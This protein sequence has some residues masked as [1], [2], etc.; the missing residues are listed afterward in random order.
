MVRVASLSFF[1]LWRRL[2][3]EPPSCVDSLGVASI[4]L[5][6]VRRPH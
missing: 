1:L 5:Q 6:F 3:M 2:G 4:R